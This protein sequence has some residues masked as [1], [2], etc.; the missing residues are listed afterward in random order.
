M[1]DQCD[2]QCEISDIPNESSV[3]P[4]QIGLAGQ[5]LFFAVFALLIIYMHTRFVKILFLPLSHP[6]AARPIPL[7]LRLQRHF[8]GRGRWLTVAVGS[9][10]SSESFILNWTFPSRNCVP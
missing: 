8:I 6:K 1:H 10:L 9:G 2:D 3:T 5:L 4:L 7:A